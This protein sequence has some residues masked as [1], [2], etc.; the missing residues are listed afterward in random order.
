[1][2]LQLVDG[3]FVYNKE[4]LMNVAFAIS[5]FI[6]VATGKLIMSVGEDKVEFSI[7]DV[8]N[9]PVPDECISY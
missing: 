5:I 4:I 8:L 6:D 9:A 2:T 1:M 3:S 7:Q